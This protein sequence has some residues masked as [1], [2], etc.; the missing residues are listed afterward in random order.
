MACTLTLDSLSAAPLTRSS[1]QSLVLQSDAHSVLILRLLFCSFMKTS[2]VNL[3]T[4]NP[5]LS[6][7]TLKMNALVLFNTQ[8]LMVFI[9]G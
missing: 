5:I 9:S 3:N 4:G 8:K 2:S 6:V 7:L 1:F